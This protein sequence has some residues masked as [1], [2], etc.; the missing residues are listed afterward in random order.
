MPHYLCKSL[1]SLDPCNMGAWCHLPP[2]PHPPHPHP[3]GVGAGQ[4]IPLTPIPSVPPPNTDG[5]PSSLW[6]GGGAAHP[7]DPKPPP[8]PQTLTVSGEGRGCEMR[9]TGGGGGGERCDVIHTFNNS[10]ISYSHALSR[11]QSAQYRYVAASFK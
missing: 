10:L 1:I 5:H 11:F 7:P 3:C 4:P 8:P 2:S 9:T 6:R